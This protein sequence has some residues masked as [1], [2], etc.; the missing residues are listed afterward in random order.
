MSL[1]GVKSCSS[2]AIAVSTLAAVHGRPTRAAARATVTAT[3]RST[4]SFGTSPIR[5]AE[6]AER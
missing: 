1:S 5:T 2:A 3:M 6:A 4:G